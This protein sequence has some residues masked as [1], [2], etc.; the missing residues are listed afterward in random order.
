MRRNTLH[1]TPYILNLTSYI[2]H[3]TSYTWHLTIE[4][5]DLITER[6]S[7]IFCSMTESLT[8]SCRSSWASRLCLSAS[9]TFTF[10]LSISLLSLVTVSW[11]AGLEAGLEA[12]DLERTLALP[13]LPWPLEG[14]GGE[15]RS[16][17][18]ETSSLEAAVAAQTAG[19]S[20]PPT[21]SRRSC[22]AWNSRPGSKSSQVCSKS[23]YYDQV[24]GSH[25]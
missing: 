7:F 13:P 11:E 12:G 24:K 22:T 19:P 14:V 21:P 4:L 25:H 10:R 2:L 20:P 8:L 3:L 23:S 1:L 18:G 16:G 17:L 9:A 5:R 15:R 6:I